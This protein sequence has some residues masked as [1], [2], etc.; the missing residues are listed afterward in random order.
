MSG[1][2]QEIEILEFGAGN[3]LDSYVLGQPFRKEGPK[4][5]AIGE[6]KPQ[7]PGDVWMYNVLF[8][9][10]S[11]VRVFN[12]TRVFFG[13]PKPALAKVEKPKLIY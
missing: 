6:H 5:T 8:E 2:I 3:G 12:H 13:K 7:G 10:G 4:V 1:L 11:A 9:D